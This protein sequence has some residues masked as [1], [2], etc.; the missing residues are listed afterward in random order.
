VLD[1]LRSGPVVD[2]DPGDVVPVRPEL[3]DEYDVRDREVLAEAMAGVD[4][5]Y[6]QAAVVSVPRSVEEPTESHSVNAEGTLAVLEAARE[7]DARVVLASS[8]AVYGRPEGVP[9]PETA[10]KEPTSPYGL[11]KLTLDRYARLYHELYGLEQKGHVLDCVRRGVSLR[12]R[13]DNDN[14]ISIL[15]VR[16]SVCLTIRSLAT[17]NSAAILSRGRPRRLPDLDTG[18]RPGQR[19]RPRDRSS[20]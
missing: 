3:S 18:R 16:N 7:V 8:A 14:D 15:V 6:H 13:H 20:R 10:A 11:E 17:G 12:D 1:V 2:A 9:I 5:V 19:R 4:L